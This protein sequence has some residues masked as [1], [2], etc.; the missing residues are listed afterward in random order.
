MTKQTRLCIFLWWGLRSMD[1]GLVS[2]VLE[3]VFLVRDLSK[4]QHQGF[5]VRNL[6]LISGW[7]YRTLKAFFIQLN[8]SITSLSASVMGFTSGSFC[9]CLFVCDWS[10]QF[11]HFN[12]HNMDRIWWLFLNNDHQQHFSGKKLVWILEKNQFTS[13]LKTQWVQKK[14]IRRIKRH[15]A[16]S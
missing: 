12:W 1:Q 14:C 13:M 7:A 5:P 6:I 16:L 2:A 10:P 4:N 11:S 9:L 3:T 15:I 8:K